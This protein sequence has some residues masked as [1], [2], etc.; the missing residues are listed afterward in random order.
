[1]VDGKEHPV[2]PRTVKVA[3]VIGLSVTSVIATLPPVFVTIG[4][5]VGGIPGVVYL[6][7]LGVWVVLAGAALTIAY[8]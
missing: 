1:M 7:L 8:T 3:R 6:S 5:A 2:D 4:W